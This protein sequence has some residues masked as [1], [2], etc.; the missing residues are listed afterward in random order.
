MI[1]VSRS[2]KIGNIKEIK[3]MY[4]KR[5]VHFFAFIFVLLCATV[6][7]LPHVLC[8]GWLDFDLAHYTKKRHSKYEFVF[9]FITFLQKIFNN[10][11]PDSFCLFKLHLLAASYHPAA[12]SRASLSSTILL[13]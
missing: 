4:L 9:H 6:C 11:I 5:I 3:I 13:L 10:I 12:L 1:P 2:C 7:P 8:E